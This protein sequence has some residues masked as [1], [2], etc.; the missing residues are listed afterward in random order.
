MIPALADDLSGF[1]RIIARESITYDALLE[2]C[3]KTGIRKEGL[4]LCPDPAFTLEQMPTKVPEALRDGGVVGI[5]ISPMV[6]DQYGEASAVTENYIRLI[7]HILDNTDLSVM[8]IPHVVRPNGDDR[9][10][11]AALK[12]H[13]AGE[14]R[15]VTVSDRSAGELKYLIGRCRFFVGARTHATIAAYSLLVPTLV[16]G[17]SVKSRGI[18]RDL[19]GDDASGLVLPVQDMRVGSELT[20]AFAG[21]AEREESV[22][23][24]LSAVM[25]EYVKRA[26]QNGNL[27]TA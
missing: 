21:L 19:F 15:I 12:E 27:I 20:D 16:V 2:S 1:S 4:Y 7:R 23:S 25:P 11:L 3:G 18:A 5:N 9:K 10:A 14:S 26:G 17:Y 8:L 13:F 24:K 22:R 6:R